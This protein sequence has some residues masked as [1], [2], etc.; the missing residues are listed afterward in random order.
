LRLGDPRSLA[1]HLLDVSRDDALYGSCFEWKKKT[2]LP[3]FAALL[4]QL[5]EHPFV[6]LCK[7]VEEIVI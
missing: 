1:R 6:R 3:K 5:R 4:G 2:F 7:K